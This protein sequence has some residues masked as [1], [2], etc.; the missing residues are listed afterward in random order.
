MK[1][2]ALAVLLL[3]CVSAVVAQ[4]HD[5]G[6]SGPSETLLRAMQDEMERSLEHLRL[7]DLPEPY[8][9]AYTVLET[10]RLQLQ[11]NFG[12]LERPV[13]DSSRRIQVEVR[14]GSREFDDRHFVGSQGQAYRPL[15]GVL[16][17]EDGYDALRAAIWTLTDKAYKSSLERLTQKTIYRES[18]NIR[19]V[20]PDLSED[21]VHTS[22]ET[23]A[24]G[25][26]ER[27]TLERHV[28]EISAVFRDFPAIQSSSVDALWRARHVYFVDSEGRRYVKPGHWFELRMK[29]AAQAADGMVQSDDRQMV[30]SALDQV[31]PVH[32]LKAAAERLAR[33]LTDL[34]EAAKIETYLGPVL[35]EGQAA[36]EFFSQLLASGLANPREVWVAHKW[37]ARHYKTGALTKRLGLRVISPMF[38]V[39]DDPTRADYRGRPLTGHY[40][41]DEQ[42]IPAQR[43]QLVER[44][45][46]RDLLMSRSPTRERKLSNGHGRGGFYA[47][48][49]A[50]IGNLFVTPVTTMPLEKMKRRLREEA[51]SF[52]LSHGILIRR[53]A[54]ERERSRDDLLA[55]PVLV[56]EVDVET[57]EERLVRD[58]VFNAVTL[59]ALRD[60]VAASNE[61]HVYNLAK[62]GAYASSATS[63]ASIVH[64][65]V[66]L[67]EMELVETERKPSQ[68]PYLKHPF[69]DTAAKN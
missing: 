10:H 23:L 24:T 58:A 16:P 60:I 4:P 64:P 18:N 46:L 35:L 56:Y 2:F 68:P 13:A 33:D 63:R 51:K 19:D 27:E 42:G 9:L 39:V 52:G 41:I 66:L 45:I 28:R 59:R 37:S 67:S 8:F 22:V 31:P 69:F 53:I 26:F 57:G 20:L 3:A 49:T 54:E 44:G 40:K 36:G 21:P 62:P 7:E 38:D 65:S 34:A 32:E 14:T 5:T 15:T 43:V 61:Q 17:V 6:T 1:R 55:E 29:A 47:P 11:G 12:A 50:V 48:A 30:W 25:P